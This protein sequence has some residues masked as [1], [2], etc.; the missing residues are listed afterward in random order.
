MIT[1]DSITF[2]DM[3]EIVDGGATIKWS[4]RTKGFGQVTIYKEKGGE[5]V[6][7]MDYPSPDL[8]K[9]IMFALYEKLIIQ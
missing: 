8:L 4:A 6:A 5:L 2:F 9:E 1:I 7:E 3:N